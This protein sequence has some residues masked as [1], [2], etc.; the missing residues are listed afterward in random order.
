MVD[1]CPL[2]QV[3]VWTSYLVSLVQADQH[4]N[5]YACACAAVSLVVHNA[6]LGLDDFLS[7]C[8]VSIAHVE[9]VDHYPILEF[10]LRKRDMIIPASKRVV[11]FGTTE[12]LH[13]AVCR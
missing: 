5:C 1:A 4:R 2:S 6:Q 13:S 8:D 9:Q 7:L 10:V 12:R 11:A 3:P